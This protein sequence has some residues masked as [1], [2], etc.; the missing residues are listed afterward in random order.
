MLAVAVMAASSG[1]YLA[2]LLSSSS[3]QATFQSSVSATEALAADELD[4][5]VGQPRPD[6]SLSD[7]NGVQVSAADFDGQVLL[8]NF[9]ATWCAPCVE[10]MPMLSE[11]QQ[12]YGK[13]GFQVVGIALDDP[14]KASKFAELLDITYPALF[15]TI[16]AV[17][18]GREYGNRAGMLPYSVLVDRQ[19][20]VQWAYLGALQ[21]PELETLIQSLL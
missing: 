21:R 3:D 1:Y 16:D 15:G 4:N 6:Y 19:G 8:I 11:L 5:L 13:A 9:W 10:E 18:V 2:M 17:L 14:Q 7:S 12:Q 20:I